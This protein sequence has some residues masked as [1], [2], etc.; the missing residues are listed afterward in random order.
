[1]E[2]WSIIKAL[3]PK[4][5]TIILYLFEDKQIF[6]GSTPLS[7]F[8]RLNTFIEVRPQKNVKTYFRIYRILKMEFHKKSM[9]ILPAKF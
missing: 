2:L 5:I 6:S 8:I 4:L 3:K 7:L 9:V 1:M